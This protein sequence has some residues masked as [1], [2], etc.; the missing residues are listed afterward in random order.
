V[1]VLTGDARRLLARLRGRFDFVLIDAAKTEYLDYLRRLE[2]RLRP[3]AV[4]VADNT[5]IFRRAV[6]PYLRYVRTSG[7]YAS[8]AYD[9]GADA[10]EVSVFRPGR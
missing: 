2:P 3:G 5:K 1:R 6:G 4:I 9:F 10:M 8:R 7:R